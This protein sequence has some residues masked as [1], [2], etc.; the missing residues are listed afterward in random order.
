MV[1]EPRLFV[2]GLLH[3]SDCPTLLGSVAFNRATLSKSIWLS[4]GARPGPKFP[5]KGMI[6]ACAATGSRTHTASA[7]HKQCR[8]RGR[9]YS[10]VTFSAPKQPRDTGSRAASLSFH[11]SAAMVQ[12]KPRAS[13]A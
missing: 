1:E 12:P 10:S 9:M 2:S 4:E 8:N 7:D 5:A 11:V 3:E 13:T 6:R